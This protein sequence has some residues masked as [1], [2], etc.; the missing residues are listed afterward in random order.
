MHFLS[1]NPKK[2]L[3]GR[4]PEQT[5]KKKGKFVGRSPW[6]IPKASWKIYPNPPTQQPNP[7]D[8]QSTTDAQVTLPKGCICRICVVC[9]V[10]VTV[11]VT[12]TVLLFQELGAERMCP[13]WM[14]LGGLNPRL[15]RDFFSMR[16]LET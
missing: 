4:S 2:L 5:F 12:V 10:T 9:F 15:L 6:Q 13:A 16:F 8:Q 7:R 14:E 11:T 3:C 1:F